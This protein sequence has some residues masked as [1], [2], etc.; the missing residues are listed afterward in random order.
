M[1]LALHASPAAAES[2]ISAAQSNPSSEVRGEALFWLAQSGTSR[3]PEV[4]LAA[5]Q[6]DADREVREEA[7][8]ALSQLPEG[9]GVPLLLAIAQ[10]PDQ[11]S[12]IRQEAFFWFV[13][14]GDDQALD[15]IAEIL[16]PG[17]G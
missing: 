16:T 7:V 3:A 8:F 14:E 11:P 17:S 2:L 12:A 6:R 4:I 5:L 15:L 10:D 9:R 1:A 13:Q